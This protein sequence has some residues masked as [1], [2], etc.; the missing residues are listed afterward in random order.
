MFHKFCVVFFSVSPVLCDMLL[1]FLMFYVVC[2]L[3]FTGWIS[4]VTPDTGF[5]T[6]L[7][8]WG[9]ACYHLVTEAP[10]NIEFS[11]VSGEETFFNLTAKQADLAPAPGPPPCKVA[12]QQTNIAS[13]SHVITLYPGNI[14]GLRASSTFF[15]VYV[16][17]VYYYLFRIWPLWT[18]DSDVHSRYPQWKS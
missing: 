6:S 5:E 9:R 16:C 10:H 1:M 18:S 14:Q 7:A 15:M 17:H 12:P 3:C 11:R 13:T 4:T 8:I 2:C